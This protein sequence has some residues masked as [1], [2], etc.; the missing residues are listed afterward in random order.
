M[1]SLTP[2]DD[3]Y[4]NIYHALDGT[5]TGTKLLVKSS[6]ATD[7]PIEIDQI[8]AGPLAEWK[9]N[10]V[11]KAS[12][13]NDGDLL[14]NGITGAAGVYT[15]GSI[16]VGPAS[17]PTTDNQLTRRAYVLGLKTAFSLSFFVAD[18]STPTVGAVIPGTV[19]WVCPAG[20]A[21]TLTQLHVSYQS[22]SHTSGGSVS[23]QIQ[24]RSAASNWVTITNF[25]TPTLDNAN[26]AAFKVYT[27]DITDTPIAT[28]DTLIM[29]ISARSGTIT[30]R[31]VT[32]GVTGTQQ[33]F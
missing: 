17:N 29:F 6:D 33:V 8:G 32:V 16:P 2:L 5:T 14:A 23:F 22:Q 24:H 7:P 10:G 12:I 30:E 15:F 20:T 31:D 3:E 26:N 25:G 11:L 1:S 28:G 9:Q 18:P 13:E 4:N 19:T 27:S 21:V